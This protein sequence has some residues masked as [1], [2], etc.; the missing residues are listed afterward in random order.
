MAEVQGFNPLES[1]E[2]AAGGT[3]VQFAI[4][5]DTDTL[6]WVTAPP[7]AASGPS[8]MAQGRGTFNQ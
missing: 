5:A 1:S 8:T 4:T 3:N 2:R 6:G 7:R